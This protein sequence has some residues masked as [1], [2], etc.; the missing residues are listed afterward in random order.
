MEQ[1][2][3][4]LHEFNVMF[5]VA[6]VIDTRFS[7]VMG[8]ADEAASKQATALIRKYKFHGRAPICVDRS[9]PRTIEVARPSRHCRNDC[10]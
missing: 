9:G 3:G 5:L 2:C 7:A 1:L 4:E 10:T 6:Q 8:F